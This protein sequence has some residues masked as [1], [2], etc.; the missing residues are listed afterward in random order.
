MHS[1]HLLLD[2]NGEP[3][4]VYVL[5]GGEP[6]LSIALVVAAVAPVL[7]AYVDG[8]YFLPGDLVLASY[9]FE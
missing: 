5:L 7:P 4:P 9:T 1:D 3:L 8:V 6:L 2:L